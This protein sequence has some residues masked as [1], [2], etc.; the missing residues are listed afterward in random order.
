LP[1]VIEAG[2]ASIPDDLAF[3]VGGTKTI[4]ADELAA[5][6]YEHLKIRSTDDIRDLPVSLIPSP[7][8]G[9]TSHRN[10]TV[11]EEVVK[12]QGKQPKR[13]EGRAPDWKG[14]GL[15]TI[16]YWREV[17]PRRLVLPSMSRLAFRR[18]DAVGPDGSVV[19][20][21]QIQEVLT[22]AQ[23]DFRDEVL[24]CINLLQENV[25]IV[26][27]LPLDA[28][29]AGVLRR[30]AEDIGWE[31]LPNAEPAETRDVVVRKLGTSGEPLPDLSRKALERLELIQRLQP[32]HL[33]QGS[34]GFAGYFTAVL[35]HDLVVFENLEVENALYVIRGDWPAL[36]RLTRT[37]LRAQSA[38]NI[39][40]IIHTPG[41]EERLTRVVKQARGEQVD[42]QGELF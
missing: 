9:R 22:K 14:G 18:A 24:R 27:L 36:S 13:I 20:R 5:G 12:T 33:F 3:V 41:W 19:V 10:A 16:H 31:L 25:G 42:P 38:G 39:E 6:S 30:A 21:F 37:E 29:E 34:G 35:A 7:N 1:A 28:A 15:H 4:R 11:L 23:P 32:L 2:L 17:W 40:R 26:D 8:V